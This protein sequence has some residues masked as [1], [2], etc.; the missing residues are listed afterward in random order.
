MSDTNCPK[1][2]RDIYKEY[3]DYHFAGVSKYIRVENYHSFFDGEYS[4]HEW[5]VKCICPRC[6]KRFWF[7]DSDIQ[8][9]T[10]MTR[11]ERLDCLCRLRSGLV[12]FDIPPK[13]RLMLEEAL[14]DEIKALEQDTVP[15][16]FELY[17]AGLMCL[18]KDIIEVL[19]KIRAEI[20]DTGAYEQEVNGKTEFLKGINYC[21]GV[22]DK[23]KA[24][25]E[26]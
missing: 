15:F 17:Q 8:K 4:G 13:E 18:P 20:I 16:D 5:D 24:E 14:S 10:G 6:K 3:E 2:G 7:S 21:L 19:D 1:C 26:G 25:G 11:E 12:W 22:I 9:G 23:Y